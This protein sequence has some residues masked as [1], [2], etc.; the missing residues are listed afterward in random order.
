MKKAVL[1]FRTRRDDNGNK[2]EVGYF[3]VNQTVGIHDGEE[4]TWKVIDETRKNLVEY[5]GTDSERFILHD[6][7]GPFPN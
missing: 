3:F 5:A 6:V 4:L 1:V 2:N 7:I